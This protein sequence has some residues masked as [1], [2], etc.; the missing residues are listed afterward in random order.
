[1][2]QRH[3]ITKFNLYTIW[4]NMKQYFVHKTTIVILFQLLSEKTNTP[5]V[6]VTKE[7]VSELKHWIHFPLKVSK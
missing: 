6:L 7:K 2:Q 5:F 3:M 1:M 4:W